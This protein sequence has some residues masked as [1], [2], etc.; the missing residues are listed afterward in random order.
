MFKNLL[1]ISLCNLYKDKAYS[2]INIFG[3]T[4]GITCSLFLLLYI[5]DELSFDRYHKNADNIYRI[6]SHIKEPDNA[7][8]W[9][10]TQTP[11]AGEL[12]DNYP[13]VE[14]AV[15]FISLDRTLYKIGEKQFPEEKF[16]L[17]DST[18][19][20]M[21]SYKF[22]SGDPS[23]ALDNSFSIVLTESIAKKYFPSVQNALGESIQ[24]QQG[25]TFKITGI[26]EDVPPNSHFKFDALI[27][28]NSRPKL[29]SHWG[30]FG[31]YT[32]IQLPANYDLSKM[33]ASLDK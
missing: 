5:L 22:I 9:A 6:I 2:A 24:N 32:Y 17:A 8:T 28:K 18:V 12:D 21:F 15:R 4:I 1:K 19:F 29:Q 23:T 10:S 16:F 14:N 3:L 11:L 26:M 33:Q 25:E 13:E 20:D 27:S 30:G 7:F 31:V